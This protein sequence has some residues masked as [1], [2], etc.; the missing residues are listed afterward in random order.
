[1]QSAASSITPVTPPVFEHRAGDIVVFQ[2]HMA[3]RGALTTGFIYKILYPPVEDITYYCYCDAD[4]VGVYGMLSSLHKAAPA[5]PRILSRIER[6]WE[7]RDLLPTPAVHP[8]RERHFQV[9]EFIAVRRVIPG[10]PLDTFEL[11]TAYIY[12]AVIRS[13]GGE[14]DYWYCDVHQPGVY[15]QT[16]T[17]HVVCPPHA[18]DSFGLERWWDEAEFHPHFLARKALSSPSEETSPRPVYSPFDWDNDPIYLAAKAKKMPAFEDFEP[19]KMPAFKNFEPVKT[20]QKMPAFENFDPVKTDKPTSHKK[21]RR[22][23]FNEYHGWSPDGGCSHLR[24]GSP[25]PPPRATRRG[26]KRASQ[27]KTSKASPVPALELPPPCVATPVP[28]KARATTAEELIC[29]ED[30]AVAARP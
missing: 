13:G 27:A 17:K 2:H 1:M 21:T 22:E 15:G 18:I 20:D 12:R 29:H 26:R 25:A 6:W 24:W 9:G 14:A 30:M 23:S 4:R 11:V 8:M 3:P 16:T 7:T 19:V 10:K 28:A 5:P